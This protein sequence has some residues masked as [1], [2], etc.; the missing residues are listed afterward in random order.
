MGGSRGRST[1]EG[2]DGG[3]AKHTRGK[4][5]GA[6]ADSRAVAAIHTRRLCL[7]LHPSQ[8]A[9]QL[10]EAPRELIQLRRIIAAAT[11]RSAFILV[12]IIRIGWR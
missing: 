11:A 9:F 3:E 12:V 6:A 1:A 4:R 2:A 8:L 5:M 10:L 7:S